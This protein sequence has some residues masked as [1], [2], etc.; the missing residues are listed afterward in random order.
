MVVKKRVYINNKC[1][2]SQ[3]EYN[4]S[5]YSN[6]YEFFKRVQPHTSVILSTGQTTLLP[7]IL[8]LCFFPH[9]VFQRPVHRP[10]SRSEIKIQKHADP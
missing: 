10:K 4:N 8:I 2:N 7:Y 6:K 1:Y 9:N 3:E 5:G